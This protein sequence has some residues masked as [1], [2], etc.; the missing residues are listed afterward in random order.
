MPSTPK[1]VEVLLLVRHPPVQF[2]HLFSER[3][4]I[5]TDINFNKSSNRGNPGCA[6]FSFELLIL[7][8]GRRLSQYLKGPILR[9]G[10]Y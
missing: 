3:I 4:F 7:F 6:E 10:A 1:I 8:C 9:R 2:Q 5:E